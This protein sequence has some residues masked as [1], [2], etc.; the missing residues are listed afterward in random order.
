MVVSYSFKGVSP[1]LIAFPA[2]A[3]YVI[4]TIMFLGVETDQSFRNFFLGVLST[5]IGF[6]FGYRKAESESKIKI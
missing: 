3:S 4:L 2:K 5:I 1:V 6:Y